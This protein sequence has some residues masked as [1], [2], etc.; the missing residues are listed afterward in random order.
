MKVPLKVSFHK[1]ISINEFPA[2]NILCT[3]KTG[4]YSNIILYLFLNVIY[5]VMI[6][7]ILDGENTQINT[8]VLIISVY[9]S[10]MGKCFLSFFPRTH[11]R[12][13]L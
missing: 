5:P 4:L 9:M 8:F 11:T 10:L 6:Y 12:K 13:L 2:G 3:F 1:V 7:L